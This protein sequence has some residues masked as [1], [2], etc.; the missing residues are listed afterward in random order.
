MIFVQDMIESVLNIFILEDGAITK[1]NDSLW[2]DQIE[3]EK[4][5]KT[6]R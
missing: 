1:D 2:P 6:I 5:L 4:K 3:A